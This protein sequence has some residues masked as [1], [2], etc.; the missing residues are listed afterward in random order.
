MNVGGWSCPKEVDGICIAIKKECDPGDKGCVLYGKV[1]F[2]CEET[3]SNE[4]FEKK[5]E[6]KMKEMGE[7][8][9]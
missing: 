6:R 8:L 3:P 1:K 5:M 4:A 2:A 9:K 7:K